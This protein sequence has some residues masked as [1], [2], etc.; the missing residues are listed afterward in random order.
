M[1]LEHLNDLELIMFLN[2][3]DPQFIQEIL[4]IETKSS[5]NHLEKMVEFDNDIY[6]EKILLGKMV[7][8]LNEDY[9]DLTIQSVFPLKEKPFLRKGY[10]GDLQQYK[11]LNY[12]LGILS[13][14]EVCE[15]FRLAYGSK[16]VLYQKPI[17]S[18]AEQFYKSVNVDVNKK[19]KFK[20]HA[21]TIF[22]AA[23]K[24]GFDF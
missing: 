23:R 13:Y 10:E 3:A 11:E 5:F 16:Y 19:E 4:K 9:T 24:K 12:D 18:E 21:E 20:T 14:A 7:F 15:V 2:D 8:S 17:S 6:L 1:V 22:E